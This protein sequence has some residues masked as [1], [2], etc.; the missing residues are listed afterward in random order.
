MR[1]RAITS[2]RIAPMTSRDT[3]AR[4]EESSV[5]SSRDAASRGR[6][7]VLTLNRPEKLNSTNDRMYM[8]LEAE[9]RAAAADDTVEVVALTGAP[10]SRYFCSGGDLDD[11]YDPFRAGATTK[12]GRGT[13]FDPMGRFMR[14]V[15]GFPKPLV[16]CANGPAVGVG[17]TIVGLADVA[18]CVP[19]TFFMIPLTRLATAPGFC[20]S[21][22]FPQILGPSLANEMLMFERRLTSSEALAHGLVSAVLPESGFLGACLARLRPTLAAPHS[23][24]SLALFKGLVR[25]G[26]QREAL[27]RVLRAEL[28]L[29][30]Q[31]AAGEDSDVADAIRVWQSAKVG[32]PRAAGGAK[33]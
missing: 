22:T 17:A 30:D 18:F 14:E 7:L 8:R 15:I 13:W 20:C 23:G 28:A 33:L 10:D 6:I 3:R 9:L 12:T 11:G 4:A 29:V 16:V 31:R 26:A 5:L 21:A 27:L 19:S 2:H 1:S 25:R 24:R 32:K